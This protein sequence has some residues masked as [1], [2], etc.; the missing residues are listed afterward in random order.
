MKKSRFLFFMCVPLTGMRKDKFAYIA[1]SLGTAWNEAL[2]QQ[3]RP[4]R[5]IKRD[6]PHIKRGGGILLLYFFYI[7]IH[8]LFFPFFDSNLF[9][10]FP[11]TREEKKREYISCHDFEIVGSKSFNVCESRPSS[12]SSFSSSSFLIY[13]IYL[14][15][16]SFSLQIYVTVS[17]VKEKG[18]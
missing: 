3:L 15:I 6:I 8:S 12:I 2:L 9:I 11:E 18:T 5:F 14:F 10:S 16:S 13:F 7:F 4:Q 17:W 1:K